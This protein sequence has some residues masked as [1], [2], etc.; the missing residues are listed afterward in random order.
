M[1]IH[2]VSKH[3]YMGQYCFSIFYGSAYIS[4]ASIAVS[5]TKMIRE[6]PV[7]HLVRFDL[8]MI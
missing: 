1:K 5:I 3:S 2:R 8:I 6:I 7:K 4:A